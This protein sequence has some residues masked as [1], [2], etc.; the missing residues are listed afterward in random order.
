MKMVE[1]STHQVLLGITAKAQ[2]E[3]DTKKEKWKDEGNGPYRTRA[4]GKP[5]QD[6]HEHY[7]GSK[8]CTDKDKD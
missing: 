5:C 2:Q 4:A 3:G 8:P 1:E 6:G 7:D